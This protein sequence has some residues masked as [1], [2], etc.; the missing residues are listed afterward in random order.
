MNY[1][2]ICTPMYSACYSCVSIENSVLFN[3]KQSAVNCRKVRQRAFDHFYCS[4]EF[5]SSTVSIIKCDVI[6]SQLV[7]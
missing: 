5:I 4:T 7:I 3:R 2:T 6:P 1:L